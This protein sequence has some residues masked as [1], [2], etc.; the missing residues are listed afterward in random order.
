MT[1]EVLFRFL[2]SLNVHLNEMHFMIKAIE[3]LMAVLMLA[4]RRWSPYR[5][6][7]SCLLMLMFFVIF[8]CLYIF[9]LH[10]LEGVVRHLGN[11]HTF[12]KIFLTFLIN[13]GKCRDICSYSYL[14][15]WYSR[16]LI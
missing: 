5:T 4:Q 9:L 1:N 3:H 7:Q 11:F 16:L 8:F 2:A 6:L 15:S 10:N 14:V 13:L 12:L